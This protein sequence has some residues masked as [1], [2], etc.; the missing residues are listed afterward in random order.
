M[1]F[2]KGFLISSLIFLT[3]I[4]CKK[5][6]STSSESIPKLIIKINVDSTLARLGNNGQPVSMTVGHAGQNPVFNKIGAHYLEFSPNAYTAIGGGDVMYHAPETTLGGST[7]IDFDQSKIIAPGNNFLE[8]PLSE[9][10]PG[11]YNYVRVSLSYQNYDVQFYYG[12]Q[13][14]QGTIASFVGYNSYIRNYIIKNQQVTVNANK[15]QGYWGIETINGVTTGQSPAGATTVP[16]PLFASS[17]I[18]AGSCLVTG[19]FNTP[20]T[21]TGNETTD[22][23]VN[24]NL[25]IN[26]SFEWVD[27]NGNGKWDVDSS[28][29]V[30]DMGLRGLFPTFSK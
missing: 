20:L 4:S 25:S 1:P 6:N 30:V 29:S 24:L 18:P 3:V 8:L 28:E 23:I 12:G 26:K 21:I 22:V 10:S 13:P 14:Y 2:T 17:P 16:N 15:L 27:G 19:A 7:A 11:T 5:N 9:L